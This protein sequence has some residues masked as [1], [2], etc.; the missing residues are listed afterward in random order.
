MFRRWMLYAGILVILGACGGGD[1]KDGEE[2]YTVSGL[3]EGLTSGSVE[4]SN[5]GETPVTLSENA[6]FSF[7]LP[8][9]ISFEIV[10]DKNPIEQLC[11]VEN[12]SSTNLSGNITNVQVICE[13][14]ADVTTCSGNADSDGDSLSD[15]AELDNWGTNPWLS[16]T[17]GDSFPDQDE[18]AVFDPQ[19]NNYIFNP[20]IA[21]MATI[22]V[23]L[24]S[25]PQIEL[26]FTESTGTERT[27]ST[28]HEQGT[29]ASISKDW[30]G[31][32]SR[33]I[34]IG[35]T[36]SV[37][38][39]QTVGVE[40]S[41]SLFDFG[42]KV[43]YENSLTIG[44]ENSFSQT[45]GSSV[46]W[47]NSQEQANSSNYAEALELSET[48]GTSFEGGTLMVTAKVRNDGNIPYDLEN[49][50]L[51]AFLFDPRRPFDLE[52][53]GTLTYSG[54]G[55]P[56]T[57]ILSGESPPLN[58]GADV[59]LQKAQRL[60]RD[61]DN[62]VIMPA[63][64]R[65][66]NIDDNSI[67]LAEQ[68][69][70]VRTATVIVD[71]GI[72]VAKQNKY[73]VAINNGDGTRAI[74]VASALEDILGLPII[75]AK[76]QWIFGNDDTP[77]E[78]FHGLLSVRDFAMD[79]T[80]NQYWL[81]AHNHTTEAGA[82][83]RTTDFYHLLQDTYDLNEIMLRAGDKLTLVYVGDADRDALS[84]RME[85]EYGTD[86]NNI[87]SDDDSLGDAEEVYGWLTNLGVPPCDEGDLVR[88]Y[89]NPL[90][91]DSDNDGIADG[92]EKVNCQN[93]G[94]NF[95][96]RAGEDQY[97]NKGA[98]VT[99]FGSLQSTE[100]VIGI[101]EWRLLKGPD[102]MFEGNP[103]R[104]LS[105]RSPTFTA[106]N[107]VSTLAFELEV[108]VEGETLSDQV[109]IQIQKDR[110][111]A[112]YIGVREQGITPDGT[113]VAPYVSFDEAFLNI[114]SGE[115]LYVMTQ[116]NPYV[117]VNTL[118]IPDGT[119]LFGGYG[120]DWVRD[121]NNNKTP[122]SLNAS[123]DMQSVMR[124]TETSS[125]MWFSGF[126]L[127][128]DGS[129]GVA[130]NNVVALHIVGGANQEGPV[131][132]VNNILNASDVV[133][134]TSE[135]SGSSYA[136]HVSNVAE[137]R[138]YNNALIAGV[139]GLG[140]AGTVGN[141][142]QN[143]GNASARIGGSGSP[144][145]NGGTGGI[146]GSGI[147]LLAGFPGSAGGNGTGGATG[148][149]GGA[150]GTAQ[151][152]CDGITDKGGVGGQGGAGGIGD[153]GTGGGDFDQVVTAGYLSVHGTI[154]TNG[155]HG[156]GGGGGGGG[157]SCF[158]IG[159]LG[160]GGGE[161]GG[162]GGAGTGGAGGGASIGIWLNAVPS[163]EVLTNR[164][165]TSDGGDGASGGDGGTGGSGGNYAN[166]TSGTLEGSSGGR[167]GQG[168]AGGDGG[169]GGGGSGGPTI[170]IWVTSGISPLITDN[171]FT[172]G[173]GGDGGDFGNGG[174]GGDSYAIF[175]ADP[176]DASLPVLTGNSVTLG[177][178]GGGGNASEGGANGVDGIA[179]TTNF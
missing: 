87:D 175:D 154:G 137:L 41:A 57:T 36:M 129:G 115:D 108:T 60:L 49:L 146:G 40:V 5:T 143:G 53:V 56:P 76:G 111:K 127:R 179:E 4:I 81:L 114:S 104:E 97:Q 100:P 23:D 121:I 10:V 109:T 50:T 21:D 54:D 172:L 78:T 178:A 119:S 88:V 62:I 138:V 161:G 155:Y 37:S 44:F 17:D 162:A 168:G 32:V 118:D 120:V 167:G 2:T 107:E 135:S 141:P 126:N 8:S 80:T 70:A 46:N 51:S 30:G 171:T 152:F 117:A 7:T 159:G 58:F 169:H 130:G 55:F 27:I 139:G 176:N 74:S 47:N 91:S 67:L 96:V 164:I 123:L 147:F 158:G 149:A 83:Q 124:I 93:P 160:G 31:E 16:D 157:A 14:V 150:G 136:L 35:H 69:V 79:T 65:L 105:G 1:T 33:Q 174:D 9:G 165:T 163:A 18:A 29:S 125:E 34:E 134:G 133:A 61:S 59:T 86:E 90:L 68:D 132:V 156:A 11:R 26:V 131:Y 82:G 64:Y 45:S 15:C 140:Q 122:V 84:D 99:L 94:F 73:R 52:P 116:E 20:R 145:G 102:V 144:G 39:T 92:D 98:S 22:A 113:Q 112:V 6:S 25:V 151:L 48:S 106:A 77:T 43:S 42:A 142:G 3:I 153:R 12:A 110:T 38:N 85:R 19:N 28:S 71:Y 66:L 128:A 170:G 13:A 177:T 101:Y 95:I 173:N 166:G 89:S 75:Q 72:H 24:T 103:V 63:T 148:G